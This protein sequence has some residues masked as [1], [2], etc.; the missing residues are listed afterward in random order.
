MELLQPH[1]QVGPESEV[2]ARRTN[3][4]EEGIARSVIQLHHRNLVHLTLV[5]IAGHL[6]RKHHEAARR[7]AAADKAVADKAAQKKAAAKKAAD[8]AKARQKAAAEKAATEKARDGD[9]A[10]RFHCGGCR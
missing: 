10:A 3:V 9:G 4:L 6:R 8:E 2:D 1:P 5:A 7:K